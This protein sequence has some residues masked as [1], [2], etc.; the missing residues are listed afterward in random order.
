MKAFLISLAFFLTM[1]TALNNNP[2]KKTGTLLHYLVRTPKIKSAKPPLIILLHGVGS[3]EK[4][5]FSFADQLPGRFLVISARAPY[6]IRQDGYAWFQI[7]YSTGQPIFNK[8][9]AEK[10]RKIIIQFIDQLK[11]QHSF[12]EEEVYICGFSQGA[13]MSLYVG[14]TRPD[15]VKG[16]AAISG[17]LLEE[18]KPLIPAHQDLKELHILIM[19][20]IND[21]TI[22]ITYARKALAYLKKININPV[23]KEYTAGHIINN[24]MFSDLVKWLNEK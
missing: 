20:G 1:D 15:L 18:T 8:E 2:V 21:N 9:Q 16:I 10:S 12:D 23:Y 19:H 4:D 3:N 17:G 22:N 7:D 11:D 5:L 24:E 13:M 6:T 14:L